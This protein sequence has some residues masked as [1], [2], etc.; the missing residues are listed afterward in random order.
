MSHVWRNGP[1]QRSQRL[2]LLAIADNANEEGIAWPST[3]TLAEKACMTT[4]TVTRA[5]DS[6]KRA[7]WLE[8][9]PRTFEHG[10][11]TY[12]LNLAKLSLTQRQDKMSSEQ[13]SSDNLSRE[14]ADS[15]RH[16]EHLHQTLTPVDQTFQTLPP[17][18][19]NNPPNP[20]LG[21]TI[22]EPSEPSR[23]I[24]AFSPA[25]VIPDW[26]PPEAWNGFIEMRRAM[27]KKPT[28]HAAKLLI[29]KLDKL[30][31]RGQDPGAVLDQ[32]T[33]NSWAGLFPVKQEGNR[34]ANVPIGKADRNLAILAESLRD[35]KRK[36]SVGEARLLPSGSD[37]SHNS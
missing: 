3:T 19:L 16:F 22:K 1:V 6:L 32:S 15:T 12:K 37:R 18:I 13:P 33:A 11:N 9:S 20:L 25:F 31:G 26:V 5:L 17:D 34:N 28:L 36:N 27:R 2:L 14:D 10:G 4:R 23:T 24:S 30:R 7:G 21:R 35:G 8:I 29:D